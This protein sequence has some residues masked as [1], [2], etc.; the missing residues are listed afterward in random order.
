MS[1]MDSRV[2]GNDGGQWYQPP[3]GPPAAAGGR[4]QGEGRRR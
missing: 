4:A 2:R 3:Y 1:R